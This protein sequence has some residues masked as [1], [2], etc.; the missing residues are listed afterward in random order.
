VKALLANGLADNAVRRKPFCTSPNLADHNSVEA[1][2]VQRISTAETLEA[3]FK[4]S[5]RAKQ[6]TDDRKQWKQK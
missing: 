1:A 2:I 5:L 3:K 6:I 4:H